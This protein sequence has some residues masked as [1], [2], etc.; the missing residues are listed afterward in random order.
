VALPAKLQNDIKQYQR[1]EQDLG[2]LSQQRMQLDLRLRETVHTLEELK[3]LPAEATI[4][5]PIGS[6]LVKAA[7][8]KQVEDLLTEEKET[9]E[10]R[11]KAAERQENGLREKFT[12][13]Q[14][15]I[16]DQLKAAGVSPQGEPAPSQRPDPD[17]E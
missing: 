14:R 7:D 3:A 6:L 11:V 9:L 5:R 13:M 10:V 8:R 12:T 15:D 1:I 17:V 4:Y 16:T 2:T